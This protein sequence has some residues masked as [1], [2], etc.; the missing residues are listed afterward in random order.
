MIYLHVTVGKPLHTYSLNMFNSFPTN[1]VSSK[2][3]QQQKWCLGFIV[4]IF[5]KCDIFCSKKEALT[6]GT[7]QRVLPNSAHDESVNWTLLFQQPTNMVKT[8][9]SPEFMSGAGH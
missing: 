4:A 9:H 8:Y 6:H 1:I 5:Y 7:V 2:E 3:R